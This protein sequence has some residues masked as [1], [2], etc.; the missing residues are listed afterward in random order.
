MNVGATLE[1]GA[2]TA[3]CVKPSM[4]ALDDP[5]DL[6]ESTAVGLATPRHRSWDSS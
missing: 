2:Q 1:A 6:A 4:S 3:E 5:S